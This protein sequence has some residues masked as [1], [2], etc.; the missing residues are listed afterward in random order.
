MFDKPVDLINEPDS[1]LKVQWCPTKCGKLAVL[2]KNQPA[3]NI[4]TIRSVNASNN[5][6]VIEDENAPRQIL[7]EKTSRSYKYSAII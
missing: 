1:I 3:I 7:I 5:L 6:N 4:Y 2:S